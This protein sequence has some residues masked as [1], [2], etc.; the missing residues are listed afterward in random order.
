MTG[1]VASLPKGT[2]AVRVRAHGRVGSD[3]D[4][5]RQPERRTTSVWAPLLSDLYR[6]TLSHEMTR[7]FNAV[8]QLAPYSDAE[9]TPSC[10]MK[11]ISFAITV[12]LALIELLEQA[13]HYCGVFFCGHGTLSWVLSAPFRPHARIRDEMLAV[14]HSSVRADASHSE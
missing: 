8:V 3:R 5:V 4:V 13:E 10:F 7:I 12:Q 1:A 2:R 9:T 14:G 11:S 6:V